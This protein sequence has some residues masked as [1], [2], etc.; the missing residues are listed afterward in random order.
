MGQSQFSASDIPQATVVLFRSCPSTPASTDRH[1]RTSCQPSDI[2]GQPH[3]GVHALGHLFVLS[4]F[5]TSVVSQACWNKD[6]AVCPYISWL[7]SLGL[8]QLNLLSRDDGSI[9][10]LL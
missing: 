9:F 1:T 4:P 3:V 2:P 5:L 10:G 6:C 8:R 7:T